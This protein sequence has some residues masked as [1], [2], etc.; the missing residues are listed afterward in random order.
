[1]KT[2]RSKLRG[3]RPVENIETPETNAPLI[4]QS[5]QFCGRLGIHSRNR[6]GG[7]EPAPLGRRWGEPEGEFEVVAT[8]Q[9]P[10]RKRP[11]HLEVRVQP[12]VINLL[13]ADRPSATSFSMRNLLVA[14]V[15][16]V[17]LPVAGLSQET[18]A[19]NQGHP[20]PHSGKQMASG[21]QTIRHQRLRTSKFMSSRLGVRCGRWLASTSTIHSYGLN[22]GKPT[23]TSSIPIGFTLKTR[24]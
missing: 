18:T 16:G 2:P 15:L 24:F 1:M 4:R 7:L 19:P 12:S 21:P 20:Q 5:M 10:G 8:D 13:T 3:I 14:M 9:G 11:H 17:I 23:S 6:P 22:C